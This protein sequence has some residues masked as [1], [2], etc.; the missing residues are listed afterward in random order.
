MIPHL[1]IDRFLTTLE[2]INLRGYLAIKNKNRE[3]D[4]FWEL[5][6]DWDHIE[7]RLEEGYNSLKILLFSYNVDEEIKSEIKRLR[8]LYINHECPATITLGTA[9][10]VTKGVSENPPNI[11]HLPVRLREDDL[12]LGRSFSGSSMGSD[13]KFVSKFTET[14]LVLNDKWTKWEWDVS[15]MNYWFKKLELSV[16]FSINIPHKDFFGDPI[17]EKFM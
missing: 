9:A 15:P 1:K 6:P 2:L 14:Q 12:K 17:K 16:S 3:V 11:G 4:V 7:R 8:K 13:I 10:F 5:Y